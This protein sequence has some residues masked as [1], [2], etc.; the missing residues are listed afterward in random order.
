MS[1][2]LSERMV[3]SAAAEAISFQAVEASQIKICFLQILQMCMET[4]ILRAKPFLVTCV[5]SLDIH[6]YLSFMSRNDV[7]IGYTGF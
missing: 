2:A 4:N 7:I 5:L 6:W 3:T 1:Q